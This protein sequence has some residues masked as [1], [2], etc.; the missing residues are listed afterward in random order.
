[1]L[2]FTVQTILAV[3]LASS[4]ALAIIGGEDV[5][6]Q[7]SLARKTVMI[8]STSAHE[9]ARKDGGSS[10]Y[11]TCSGTL[12]AR[13][14]VLTAA[15][16]FPHAHL[17]TVVM[18]G[19]DPIQDLS[20]HHEKKIKAKHVFVHPKYVKRMWAFDIALI[21]LMSE[22]PEELEIIPL[23]LSEYLNPNLSYI[24]AGYSAN[25]ENEDFFEQHKLR[26]LNTK[27]RLSKP[28]YDGWKFYY[29]G[30]LF[31]NHSPFIL[32]DETQEHKTVEGDSG[33]PLIEDNS[34]ELAQVGIT[35]D[36][37]TTTDRNGRTIEQI[38]FFIRVSI[39]KNWLLNTLKKLGA[40]GFEIRN[41]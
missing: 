18:F 35:T 39:Y 13:N 6:A 2:S 1:M 7:S 21:Q 23:K 30:P 31:S 11:Y 10:T 9:M 16:C 24:A 29:D 32:A 27:I 5:P 8:I 26:I 40:K 3:L 4:S 36:S 15:H 34:G 20:Q 17:N 38:Q 14:V 22:A 19:N 37:Y 33:G 12:I 41:D 25:S 28:E